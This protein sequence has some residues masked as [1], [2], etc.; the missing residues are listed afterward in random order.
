MY[1]FFL[2]KDSE[3]ETSTGHNLLRAISVG[4][5]LTLGFVVVFGTFG[6]LTAGL[7]SQGVILDYTP[8]VTFGSARA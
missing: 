1:R 4:A 3:K 7:L 8:Y 6:I 2:G 5:A